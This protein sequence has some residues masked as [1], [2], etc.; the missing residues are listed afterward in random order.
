MNV[1]ETRALSTLIEADVR[2]LPFIFTALDGTVSA[3]RSVVVPS[4]PVAVWPTIY[5]EGNQG[6][7]PRTIRLTPSTIGAENF[8][9]HASRRL[10][11]FT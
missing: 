3:Q 11:Q 7:F 6:I 10:F 5:K 4:T 8:N 1:H 9:H 2:G